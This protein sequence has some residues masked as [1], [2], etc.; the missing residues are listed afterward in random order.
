MRVLI[1]TIDAFGGRGG[2]AQFSRD[3][4]TSFSRHQDVTEIVALVR[5]VSRPI[6]TL[7]PKLNYDLSGLGGK[8]KF[9]LA[10]LKIILTRRFDLIYCGHVNL[11]QMAWLA[12]LLNRVPLIL[13]VYG[14]EIWQPHPSWLVRAL[15]NRVDVVLAISEFTKKKMASWALNMGEEK[16]RIFPCTVDPSHFGEGPKDPTL[17]ARY[18]LKPADKLILILCCLRSVERHKGLD[19]LLEVMP[20]LQQRDSSIKLMIAGDGDDRQR[21]EEKA[22]KLGVTRHVIFAGYVADEEKAAHYRLAD[23]FVMP[24]HGEGFGIVFLE[25]MACGVP[26]VSGDGDGSREIMI[27]F[28]D[29]GQAVDPKNLKNLEKA[30]L[31]A[32]QTPHGVSPGLDYFLFPEFENRFN[33]L[34]DELVGSV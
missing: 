22:N 24:S 33:D 14:I 10:V 29:Q 27:R 34:I 5:S 6:E 30:I 13:A 28:G 11:L 4:I 23:A 16:Y 2:E 1:L 3:I 32:L 26:V 20:M 17:L 15:L 18:G 7:P 25:A 8:N 31:I 12:A 21:L 9:I 19:P